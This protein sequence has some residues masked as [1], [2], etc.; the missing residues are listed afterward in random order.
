MKIMK[1]NEDIFQVQHLSVSI[2]LYFLLLYYIE[3]LKK[4][5]FLTLCNFFNL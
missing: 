2:I 4:K 5:S 3:L 1:K